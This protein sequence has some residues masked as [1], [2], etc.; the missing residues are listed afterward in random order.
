[1]K[2]MKALPIDEAVGRHWSGLQPAPKKLPGRCY[3]V[4]PRRCKHARIQDE[5]VVLMR[6]FWEQ[7]RAQGWTKRMLAAHF[8]TSVGTVVKILAYVQRGKVRQPSI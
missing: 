3:C 1:M 6:A 4:E 2:F 5:Q 7:D 8:C